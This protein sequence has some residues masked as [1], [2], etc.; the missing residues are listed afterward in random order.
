[1]TWHYYTVLYITGLSPTEP[2]LTRTFSQSSLS[3]IV[4]LSSQAVY[5]DAPPA[6]RFGGQASIGVCCSLL[7]S[8]SRVLHAV[9][10]IVDGQGLYRLRSDSPMPSIG[11]CR[12]GVS[13]K[14][15][16]S[17]RSLRS[18]LD[19]A[20]PNVAVPDLNVQ[21]PAMLCLTRQDSATYESTV[22][23][24][25]VRSCLGKYGGDF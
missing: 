11:A 21:N 7:A 2:N 20:G 13:R 15:G 25:N 24:N 22:L 9:A 5:P 16:D 8:I 12:G 4:S 18:L 10:S 1:M 6:Q 23:Y 17:L 19:W 3:D 14:N